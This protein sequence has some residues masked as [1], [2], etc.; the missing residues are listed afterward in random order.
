MDV[1]AQ[2]Y[3]SRMYTLSMNRGPSVI[4]A[5][6]FAGL[7]GARGNG[8]KVAVVDDGV[9]HEHRFLDPTGFSYP[10]GFPKGP[11]EGRHRR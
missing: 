1:A 4:G 9:D 3:P 5:T 11:G 2:V 6:Q 10:A 7:T 8:V